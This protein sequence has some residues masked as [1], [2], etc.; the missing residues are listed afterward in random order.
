MGREPISALAAALDDRS[1]WVRLGAARTAPYLARAA[2]PELLTRRLSILGAE[3]DPVEAVTLALAL[4]RAGIDSLPQLS[5]VLQDD[6]ARLEDALGQ[7]YD[8]WARYLN[9]RPSKLPRGTVSALERY[10]VAWRTR[11]RPIPLP[12]SPAE[13]W[14]ARSLLSHYHSWEG[15]I[16]SF[17][18]SAELTRR[19]A[20]GFGPVVQ[21]LEAGDADGAVP[22]LVE[23]AVSSATDWV[24]FIANR[25]LARVGPDA[26]APLIRLLGGASGPMPSAEA[27][28]A[29]ALDLGGEALR[30]MD[31]SALAAVFAGEALQ[32][33]GD[34]DTSLALAGAALNWP[35]PARARAARVLA[36]MSADAAL[37]ALVWSAYHLPRAA[38]RQAAISLLDRIVAK[39]EAFGIRFHRVGSTELN[40]GA[41]NWMAS[42]ARRSVAPPEW[43]TDLSVAAQILGAAIETVP[44]VVG[45]VNI[46]YSDVE[47]NH[48]VS[49]FN[50]SVRDL[51]G[52]AWLGAAPATQPRYPEATMPAHCKL[53]SEVTLSVRLLAEAG[54]GTRG[55][56]D[57]PFLRRQDSTTLLVLVTPHPAFQIR[58][59]PYAT[60]KVPR[61]GASGKAIFRLHARELGT[62]PV[63]IKFLLDN[64][65]IGHCCVTSEITDGAKG[66]RADAYVLEPVAAAA[67][68]AYTDARARLSVRTGA[69]GRLD[70]TLH[71]Q[72]AQ[73]QPLGSSATP[74]ALQDR[75]A[76]LKE[77]ADIVKSVLAENFSAADLP[78][79]LSQL[80]AVGY[81]IFAQMAP[82][83]LAAAL[84]RLPDDAL[85]VI[86][87]DADWIPWELLAAGAAG[88]VLGERFVLVRA[89]LITEVPLKP[90]GPAPAP[91]NLDQVL[92]VVGDKIERPRD[93]P[94]LIFGGLADRAD[95]PLIEP[96]W[97]KLRVRASGADII[98]FA[99]HGRSGPPYH[100][101]YGPGAGRRLVPK[102]AAALGLKPGAV[103]FANACSSGA[104]DLL[105]GE[106]QSFGREFYLSGARPFIGTLGPVPE[107]EAVEFA[108]L[109]YRKFAF[110]GLPA[111]HALREAKREA[112]ARFKSPIWLFYCL[113]GNASAACRPNPLK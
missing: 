61:K 26:A 60:I 13:G 100:L 9:A 40:P 105:L 75:T 19:I 39:D 63:D 48:R 111:G 56:F 44:E 8:H 83:G 29:M 66:G 28:A 31:A 52:M 106:F 76:W 4:A 53:G 82:S 78:G 5:A 17:G 103:V 45:R 16:T 15:R 24:R 14:R 37:P 80:S 113:Y 6:K 95:P 21:R 34:A 3:P 50:R 84:D 1:R 98:H 20:E 36:H 89:P 81:A 67:M 57:V 30:D 11:E 55:Q 64:V 97:E 96:D 110:A 41:L 85:L 108:A 51:A 94:R 7:D 32:Q 35:G 12:T 86:E 70:W 91:G 65:D 22:L 68:S 99:C 79:V 10:F 74:I 69:D 72:G 33:F 73:P 46:M 59:S 87:S 49:L 102:Q 104:P 23:T 77:Q 109:F 2:A 43:S 54:D 107:I 92:L 58:S 25:L 88:P 112:R 27:F 18:A 101:S 93:L 47:P 90:A 71:E 42:L 62:W 38:E